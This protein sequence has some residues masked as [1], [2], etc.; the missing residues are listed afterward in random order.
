MMTQTIEELMNAAGFITGPMRESTYERDKGYVY[1]DVPGKKQVNATVLAAAK[2]ILADK[3]D[4][5][6]VHF[7]HAGRVIMFAIK[8]HGKIGLFYGNSMGTGVRGWEVFPVVTR[9]S[10][11]GDYDKLCSFLREVDHREETKEDFN[12]SALLMRLE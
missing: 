1:H 4:D 5:E 3:F 9:I 11:I 2:K 6:P 8:M 10:K 12:V 7:I